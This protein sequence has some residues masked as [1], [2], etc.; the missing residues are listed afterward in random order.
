MRSVVDLGKGIC[1]DPLI[2]GRLEWLMTNGIGGYASGTVAGFRTRRYH[3]LLVAALRPPIGRALFVPKA[4]ETVLYQGLSV[5]LHADR[6]LPDGVDPPGF[7]RI[8]R[9][10]LEGTTPV[11]TFSISDALVEKRVWMEPGANTT[12]LRYDLLRAS[13]PL[14]LEIGVFADARDHHETTSA[15]ERSIAIDPIPHGIRARPGEGARSLYVKSIRMTAEPEPEWRKRFFLPLEAYRGLEAMEDLFRAARFHGTLFVGDSTTLV[16]SLD[17]E[18]D[19]DGAPAIERR[20]SHERGLLARAEGLTRRAEAHEDA[21]EQLVLA[22]DQFVVA[23]AS[24]ADPSG[25]S[26]IAGYPW[27]SDW[28]RDTMIAL[29]GLTLASGRPEIARTILLTF[30]RFLDRGMLPNRFPDEGEAPE[31]NTVDATLWYFE[32]IRAYHEATG[33][34]ELLRELFPRLVEVLD[35][36]ERGTRFGIRVDPRDG[37]LAAGEEGVQLTWMDAKAGDLVVTPRIGKPV[38]VNALWYHALRVTAGFARAI[39]RPG[40]HFDE[41]ADRVRAGFERFWSGTLGHCLDVID[42]P[43]GDDPSLRPNQLLAVSLLHSPLDGARRKAIVDVC[44]TRLLTPYGLRS[45]GA[46]HPSYSGRYGGDRL[47]RDRA[48]HQGTV[49]AWLIGPFVSAHFRVYRDAALARSFLEPFFGHLSEHGLGSVSEI[50]D[51]DPPFT[52]RGCIAQAWSVA[53]ILRVW[54]EITR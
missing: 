5:P 49:W 18:A 19:P 2:S 51:G 43:D 41:A 39:E 29:P 47:Q 31:Y 35:W 9:F 14:E 53:E 1:S 20:N 3:G 11:W 52:P 25:R 16:L 4:D 13:E 40:G 34:D 21:L 24:D 50:F 10:R 6:R 36:H 26:V 22:A 48:Y 33:D 7:Q 8:D 23:R 12:Y 37:L 44:A 45:L 17:E 32:A 38:E 46:E 28:G 54:A 42:G 27:F 15:G 30:A